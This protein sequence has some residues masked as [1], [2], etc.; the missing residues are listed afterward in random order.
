MI[1]TCIIRAICRCYGSLEPIST[2][3]RYRCV[4]DRG[5]GQ[6][7]RETKESYYIFVFCMQHL[8]AIIKL[9]GHLGKLA[10]YKTF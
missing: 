7:H 4:S 9:F 8:R 3:N 2:F 6:H 10:N 1:V 5:N